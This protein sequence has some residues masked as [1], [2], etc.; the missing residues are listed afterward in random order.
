MRT[1][2]PTKSLLLNQA[3]VYNQIPISRALITAQQLST[4]GGSGGKLA[5]INDM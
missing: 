5:F 1:S 3:N 2:T 4:V